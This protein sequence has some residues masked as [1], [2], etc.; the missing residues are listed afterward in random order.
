MDALAKATMPPKRSRVAPCLMTSISAELKPLN[1]GDM[2]ME[3]PG[4]L[5]A[6]VVRSVYVRQN[7]V[8]MYLAIS[9]SKR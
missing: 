1:C 8:S 5:Y 6:D 4:L 3:D 7:P 2:M 9:G